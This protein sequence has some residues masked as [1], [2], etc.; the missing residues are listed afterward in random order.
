MYRTLTAA[1]MLIAVSTPSLAT[2][3]PGS[4]PRGAGCRPVQLLG[5]DP[6]LTY[7]GN[8]GGSAGY[9]RGDLVDQGFGDPDVPDDIFFWL[10][11]GR[12]PGTYLLDSDINADRT[13]CEQCIEVF[14]DWPEGEPEA[15]K[16]L[17][18]MTGEIT[19]LDAPGS[20]SMRISLS[21]VVLVEIEYDGEGGYAPVPGGECY[22]DV[23]NVIFTSNF[24]LQP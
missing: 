9:Y 6:P 21:N 4:E 7:G 1:V 5:E 3:N 17:F 11:L 19:Y 18:Q 20:S 13:T 24:E 15:D 12:P 8:L 22:R 10:K 23:A 16:L 14:Q 2:N